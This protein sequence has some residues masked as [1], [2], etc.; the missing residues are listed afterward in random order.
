MLLVV[1]EDLKH[2]GL[3]LDVF[4]E[5]LGHLYSNLE[6]KYGAYLKVLSVHENSA[7]QARPSAQ[8]P[9]T[10]SLARWGQHSGALF[11]TQGPILNPLLIC[12]NLAMMSLSQH[13]TE[14]STNWCQAAPRTVH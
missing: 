1:A 10:T 11:S 8:I 4:N 12:R 6:G 7:V 2:D 13:G 14:D 3:A 9:A 5:G